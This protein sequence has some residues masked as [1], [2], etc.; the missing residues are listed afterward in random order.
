MRKLLGWLCVVL[1]ASIGLYA[2]GES[3]SKK[4]PAKKK[5]A[6]SAKSKGSKTGGKTAAKS[7]PA[8]K[9]ASKKSAGKSS[10]AR[11]KT[12]PTAS[13]AGTASKTGTKKTASKGGKNTA[14]APK[15]TWRNRQ[16][17][18]SSERYREIQ[19]ALV[20]KGF[21]TAEDATGQ[22]GP[23]SADGLKKFQEAQNIQSNGK[24]NSLSLIALGLGP[25]RETPAATRPAEPAVAKPTEVP[26]NQP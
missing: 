17:S 23:S 24:I 3:S 7:A 20:T 4:S 14:A 26:P 13:K 8:G 16:L 11:S 5:A 12:S 15:T 9:P 18:P 10:A 19:D 21:L 22:W 25:K 1:W 6:V 2:A